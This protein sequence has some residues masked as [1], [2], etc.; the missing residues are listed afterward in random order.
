[1]EK[2]FYKIW[3]YWTL[4]MFVSICI[5]ALP[6]MAIILLILPFKFAQNFCNNIF[7]VGGFIALILSGIIP[8]FDGDYKALKKHKKYVYVANHRSY[9]DILIGVLFTSANTRF[10]SKI[11]VFNWPVIGFFTT[12]LGHIPVDR[13]SPKARYE[14]L[15]NI[16][17]N[18]RDGKSLIL[19]PEGRILK[20]TELLNSFKNGAFATAID[21]QTPIICMT[22]LNAGIICP[23]HTTVKVKPGLLRIKYS[24]PIITKGKTKED[25]E[26]LKEEVYQEMY[27]NLSDYYPDKIYPL[28]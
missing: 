6:I 1:M 21:T 8:V 27:K 11:E 15:Q 23:S 16:K 17:Q 5:I 12:R 13:S 9:L 18:V 7:K 20:N 26:S 28:K 22:L 25:I 4:L 2:V 10:L 19:F 14:S 24:N 3:K